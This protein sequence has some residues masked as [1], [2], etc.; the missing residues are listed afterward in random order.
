MHFPRQRSAQLHDGTGVPQALLAPLDPLEPALRALDSLKSDIGF[1]ERTAAAVSAV[2]T[3]ATRAPRN[4][5][6]NMMAIADSGTSSRGRP[7]PV[8]QLHGADVNSDSERPGEDG[9]ES[10]LPAVFGFTAPMNIEEIYKFAQ[11]LASKRQ[12][13]ATKPGKRGTYRYYLLLGGIHGFCND[14]NVE[15]HVNQLI[16]SERAGLAAWAASARAHTTRAASQRSH[17][18]THAR[19]DAGELSGF[20]ANLLSPEAVQ[21]KLTGELKK[22]LEAAKFGSEAP[23]RPRGGTAPAPP[24][25]FLKPSGFFKAHPSSWEQR[26]PRKPADQPAPIVDNDLFCKFVDLHG[27]Y[28]EGVADDGPGRAFQRRASMCHPLCVLL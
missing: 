22:Y 16:D 4:I 13:G 28:V 5:P 8:V 9:D 12:P 27:D 7:A 14:D 15:G 6:V 19:A 20:S 10:W 2:G 21:G 1:L 17:T 23:Q 25:P 3:G 18:H 26:N 24:A 11:E